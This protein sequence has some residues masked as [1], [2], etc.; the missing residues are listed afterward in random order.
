ML[1]GLQLAFW[2][3]LLY[4]RFQFSESEYDD[5]KGDLLENINYWGL[6]AVITAVDGS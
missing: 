6:G 4:R 3:L 1:Y 2:N 5:R